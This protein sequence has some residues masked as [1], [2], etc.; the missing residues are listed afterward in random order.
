MDSL[1]ADALRQAWEEGIL[2]WKL[3]PHQRRLY[4]FVADIDNEH[5]T[6]TFLK[7]VGKCARRFGK[8]FTVLT[9]LN[10]LAHRFP[11]I[12]MRYAAP[13]EKS[14]KSYVKPNMRIILNDCPVDLKPKFQPHESMYLWPTGS[15][16]WLAG[17]DKEHAEKLRGPGT[18]I[19]V[20]DE[21]GSMSN[22]KYVVNDI[23]LPSTMDN[24]GR[25]LVISSPAKTPGH[26][27][28]L[29]CNEAE[30]EGSLLVQTV[31]QNHYLTDRPDKLQ[32]YIDASGGLE[33][34]TWKREYECQD[35]VD[36]AIAVIGEANNEQL[37][38]EICTPWERPKYFNSIT[39]MD[40][41]FSPSHTGILFGYVDFSKGTLII[42]DEID[43]LRMRTDIMA[44]RILS[45]ETQLGY[46]RQNSMGSS[47]HMRWSDIDPR[48]LV[49]LEAMHHL[50]FAATSKDNLPAMVNHARV[51]I[52]QKRIRVHP[53]CK[54][55]I[56]EMKSV[57]WNEGRSGFDFSTQF[58]HYDLISA[59]VYMARNADWQGN[60]FPQVPDGV[61]GF[62]H[63]IPE[64]M[65]RAKVGN[66]ALVAHMF[67][68]SKSARVK[69]RTGRWNNP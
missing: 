38:A 2:D 66:E 37:M 59:L 4:E 46:V 58:G 24:D 53:R 20:V 26:D 45:K 44:E 13:T 68:V 23:I 21:A 9:H 49:D 30:A 65:F 27:F 3:R 6:K 19:G 43:M 51:L 33:S 25:I 22:L 42:E 12:R 56:A 54:T 47:K 61:E 62:S 40:P 1:K 31:W 69:L 57:T 34:S 28:T 32:E 60:P 17:T 11:G 50:S 48:L 8:T 10:E 14:L 18:D 41:G 52:S 39:S 36:E 7:K 55:L 16:L 64:S 35:V 63:I 67:K 29:M 5:T 15:E